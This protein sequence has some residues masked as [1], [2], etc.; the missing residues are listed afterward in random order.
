MKIK[1]LQPGNVYCLKILM[2]I[3]IIVSTTSCEKNNSELTYSLKDYSVLQK[4]ECYDVS[5]NKLDS[6]SYKYAEKDFFDKEESGIFNRIVIH[7]DNTASMYYTQNK[8][9]KSRIRR[10]ETKNDTLFFYVDGQWYTQ[11]LFYGIIAKDKLIIPYYVSIY[12]TLMTT[13]YCS[14][15]LTNSTITIGVM[16]KDELLNDFPA[17]NPYQTDYKIEKKILYMTSA[18]LIYNLNFD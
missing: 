12:E 16:N 3:S 5:G 8:T 17:S 7:D 14:Q 18:N 1:T 2:L 9:T 13:S 15:T 6:T 10:I 11:P 4:M